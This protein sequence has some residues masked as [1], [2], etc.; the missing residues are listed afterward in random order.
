MAEFEKRI[1]TEKKDAKTD[2]KKKI[3]EL[4]KKNTDMK[5]RMDDYK[6]KG[7]EEWEFFKTDFNKSMDE[8]GQ[9][10]KDLT[11]SGTTK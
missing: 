11:A 5:K 10:V 4:E 9:S 1:A 6:A 3:A 8:L 7:K 2:Y